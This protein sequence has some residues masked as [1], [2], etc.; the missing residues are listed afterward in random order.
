MLWAHGTDIGSMIFPFGATASVSN[1]TNLIYYLLLVI[2]ISRLTLE[3]EGGQ[4]HGEVPG[5]G[6]PALEDV[7]LDLEEE[8]VPGKCGRYCRYHLQIL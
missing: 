3:R 7:Q 1:E 5:H 4:L 2:D 8:L 6:Q